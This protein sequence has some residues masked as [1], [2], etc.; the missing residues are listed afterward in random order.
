MSKR[1]A[2]GSQHS[3]KKK[4][5]SR[6]KEEWLSELIET[7][8]LSSSIKQKVKIG[9]IFTCND[10]GAVV[11]TICSRANAAGE[12]ST[13]KK[14]EEWK[15]D[16]LKRHLSQKVHTESVTKLR[17]QESGGIFADATGE[18]GRS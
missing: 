2:E 15:L 8:V 16:Y 14:W 7:D 17:N 13:G 1:K 12:F 5:C 6:F 3:V 18:Y 10:A 11:C 4:T 9:D